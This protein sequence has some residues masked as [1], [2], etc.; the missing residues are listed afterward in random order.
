MER[1]QSIFLDVG[2]H[3]GESL[4]EALR[5][6]YDFD[7]V[8]AIE[9]S[10]LGVKQLEKFKDKRLRLVRSAAFNQNGKNTLYGSGSV[11]GS[12]FVGKK[13]N[14]G[15]AEVIDCFKF[16]DFLASKEVSRSNLWIKINVEGSEL[17]LLEEILRVKEYL[18]IKSILVSVDIGK[19][20]GLKHL[21]PRLYR[22]IRD[23]PFDIRV[24]S[25]KEVDVAINLWL[26]ETTSVKCVHGIEYLKD[27]FRLWLPIYMNIRR[28]AKPL[29]PKR[30]W[31]YFALKLGP[32][33]TKRRFI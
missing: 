11:G 12:I 21:E 19:I 31:I 15:R 2:A 4:V 24:R 8:Y 32:N 17:L 27:Q 5:P 22:C 7:V 33:R 1:S 29:F 9:P 26:R 10:E 13:Q 3:I 23:F 18:K 16:G 20:N 14:W 30:F 28:L 6:I 25:E